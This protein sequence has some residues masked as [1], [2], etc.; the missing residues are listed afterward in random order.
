[1]DEIED[2]GGLTTAAGEHIASLD[3]RDQRGTAV[4]T[5]EPNRPPT[6]AVD[7][8]SLPEDAVDRDS[9]TGTVTT[10]FPAR[11]QSDVIWG[12]MRNNLPVALIHADVEHWIMGRARVVGDTALVGFGLDNAP[13][14]TFR[15][16]SLQM[17]G[18]GQ[19][20]GHGVVAHEPWTMGDKADGPFR[21]LPV[22]IST[23]A[24]LEWDEPGLFCA[25]GF[26][27]RQGGIGDPFHLSITAAPYVSVTADDPR[28][29]HIW[30]NEWVRPLLNLV[31][32]A[33]RESQRLSWVT[34]ANRKV[35]ERKP[36]L[37]H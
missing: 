35:H 1:M 2:A 3:L 10:S 26:A 14:L 30:L 19:I 33:T 24:V 29:S 20:I 34:L 8:W 32:L 12:R 6:A 17:S 21:D 22:K 37:E 9:E 11:E 23:E 31:S 15:R 36:D 13:D 28:S 4:L 27:V 7:G 18:L 16:L 25:A 5:L